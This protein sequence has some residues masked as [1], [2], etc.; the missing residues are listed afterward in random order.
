[1]TNIH[2]ASIL[3]IQ[4]Q[5]SQICIILADQER[6]AANTF[7]D[8][9][10]VGGQ[11]KDTTKNDGSASGAVNRPGKYGTRLDGFDERKR[12]KL[13]TKEKTALKEAG[14]DP[15]KAQEA[16]DNNLDIRDG[17]IRP[18]YERVIRMSEE[19]AEEKTCW[20]K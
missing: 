15:A 6:W 9:K 20:I 12:T 3:K 8:G 16:V 4:A 19:D 5:I 2:T 10:N 14:I 7:I 17:L 1:M 18:L 13:T 11:F